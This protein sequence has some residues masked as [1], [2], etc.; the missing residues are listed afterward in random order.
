MH[1]PG[2]QTAEASPCHASGSLATPN[3]PKCYC[4]GILNGT[5]SRTGNSF[6][7][8]RCAAL[9]PNPLGHSSH[10]LPCTLAPMLLLSFCKLRCVSDV[11]RGSCAARGRAQKREGQ[12]KCQRMDTRVSLIDTWHIVDMAGYWPRHQPN[13]D[14]QL[15][16]GSFGNG[17]KCQQRRCGKG[18][19]VRR[20]HTCRGSTACRV[21]QQSYPR[22]VSGPYSP[23]TGKTP[24]NKASKWVAG[25]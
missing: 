2:T 19:A 4:S 12:G 3:G 17:C 13:A 5:A 1:T 9:R 22:T 15:E 20:A 18:M 8:A 10:Q 11:G 7:R 25:P 16:H 14:R 24:S 23:H 21:P 6:L